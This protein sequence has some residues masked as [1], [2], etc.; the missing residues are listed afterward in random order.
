LPKVKIESCPC[1]NESE[2]TA[3]AMKMMV[4]LLIRSALPFVN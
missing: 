2:Q 1:A 3:K 4:S